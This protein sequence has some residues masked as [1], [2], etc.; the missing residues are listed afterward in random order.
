MKKCSVCKLPKKDDEFN[1]DIT[2]KDGLS[3]RCRVCHRE[4]QNSRNRKLIGCDTNLYNLLFEKQA[5]R[6]AICNRHQSELQ[7]AL[8]ADHDH[9]TKKVRG[10]LCSKCNLMLGYAGDNLELLQNSVEYLKRVSENP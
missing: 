2:S 4:L 7:K 3:R 10:L 6:C 8:C 1:K 9:V 5:G